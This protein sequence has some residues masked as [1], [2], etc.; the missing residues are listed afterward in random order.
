MLSVVG[1][2]TAVLT[3]SRLQLHLVGTPPP[4]LGGEEVQSGTP[5]FESHL[6][7]LRSNS[8]W[9]V[10]RP[11]STNTDPGRAN[12]VWWFVVVTAA[13]DA[14]G[15]V[16][17]YKENHKKNYTAASPRTRRKDNAHQQPRRRE[18]ERVV[19]DMRK[20]GSSRGVGAASASA[21]NNALIDSG[22]AVLHRATSMDRE[23][24]LEG[25]ANLFHNPIEHQHHVVS[26][27]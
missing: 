16:D 20:A 11:R 9:S 10:Q 23:G 17:T 2:L 3:C 15:S 5:F 12:G 14:V 21:R 8:G 25:A 18:A 13:E 7:L 1:V 22:I 19:F 26:Y 6:P 4:H 24:N 27:M